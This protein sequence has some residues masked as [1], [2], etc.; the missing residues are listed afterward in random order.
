M[1]VRRVLQFSALR[2]TFD[3]RAGEEGRNDFRRPLHG[4]SLLAAVSQ[5]MVSLHTQYHGHIPATAKTEMMG[6]DLLACVVGDGQPIR[7]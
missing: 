3:Q 1:G 2:A 7:R 4:E 5:A 6:D